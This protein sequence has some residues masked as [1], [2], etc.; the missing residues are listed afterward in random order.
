V[1]G[2]V[3][4]SHGDLAASHRRAAEMLLGPQDAVRAAELGPATAP[5]ALRADVA[6]A[7]AEVAGPAGVLVLVDLYG[8]GPEEAAATAA[9]NAR[10][11]V[12]VVAG[13]NLAM[14]L[15]ALTQR[16]SL[17][18]ARLATQVR[19]AGREGVVHV[20]VAGRWPPAA[21]GRR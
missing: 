10:R 13:L 4:V 11:P 16:R 5:A 2:L 8:D 7:V 6:G 12:E 18:L 1:I 21:E 3:L 15:A 20:P 17:P 19:R 9:A 14:V